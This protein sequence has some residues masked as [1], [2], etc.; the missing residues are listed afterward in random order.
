MTKKKNMKS[1]DMQ[2]HKKPM[3]TDIL[4][5]EF[6]QETGDVNA[7]KLYEAIAGNEKTE[8]KDGKQNK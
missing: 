8:K 6:G 5:E 2:N 7:S 3:D 1:K 4:Q